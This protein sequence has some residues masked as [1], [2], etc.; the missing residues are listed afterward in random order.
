MEKRR[1]IGIMILILLV[2]AS[3]WFG[4][5]AGHCKLTALPNEK[6][7]LLSGLT[8]TFINSGVLK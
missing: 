8:D 5:P 1:M 7:R 3:G 2:P 6:Y 4:R